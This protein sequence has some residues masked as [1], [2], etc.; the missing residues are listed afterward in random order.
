ME[1][2]TKPELVIKS[3]KVYT[4]T[5][6]EYTNGM[7]E[8]Q[9]NNDGFNSLELLGILTLSQHEV[10]DQITGKMKKPDVIKRTCITE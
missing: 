10:N 6:I 4:I 8:L 7:G 9:R 2:E 3:K 1:K 5:A